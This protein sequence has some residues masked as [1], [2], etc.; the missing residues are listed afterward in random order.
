M[1]CACGAQF[2][3]QNLATAFYRLAEHWYHENSHTHT[4]TR[5]MH[6]TDRAAVQTFSDTNVR[7]K[8]AL[9][10]CRERRHWTFAVC[11]CEFA[12]IYVLS[13][14]YTNAF[15]DRVLPAHQQQS[16][17]WSGMRDHTRPEQLSRWTHLWSESRH[18]TDVWCGC[19]CEWVCRSVLCTSH[20]DVP[21][22]FATCK[23]THCARVWVADSEWIMEHVTSARVCHT[24]VSRDPFRMQQV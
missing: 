10:L 15:E 20:I 6:C 19:V 21:V 17:S 9:H 2:S 7:R 16:S 12:R 13:H 22:N 23:R 5:A 18:V 4:H 24:S 1:N 8:I 11:V 14:S 3:T